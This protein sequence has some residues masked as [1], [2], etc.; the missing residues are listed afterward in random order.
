M[1]SPL[2]SKTIWWNGLTIIIATATYFGYT[3]DQDLSVQVT[4]TLLAVSPLINLLL[5]FV[6]KKPIV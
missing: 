6:T 4:T 3:P 2:F 5:R 1:K